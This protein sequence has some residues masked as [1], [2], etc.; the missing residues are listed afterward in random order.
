MVNRR[1]FLTSATLLPAALG[2][3]QEGP[4]G[5]AVE[6]PVEKITPGEKP[7]VAVCHVGFRPRVG[8]KTLVVRAAAG[9]PAKEL[10][11]GVGAR[12][13]M[14]FLPGGASML[15]HGIVIACLLACATLLQGQTSTGTIQGQVRDASGAVVPDARV[16]ITNLRTGVLNELRTN[17]EGRYVMPF[18]L[19]G[20]YAIAVEK[21]GFQRFSRSGI[22]LDVGQNE[23]VD[24]TLAV[25]DVATTVQVEG[26]PPPLA[27][28]SST[29]ATVIEN[30]RIADL[31]L[32]GRNPFDLAALSPGVIPMA[33]GGLGA[34]MS[35]TP[36]ISGGRDANSEISIDGTSIVL[37]ENNVS[38]TTMAFTPS[39]DAIQEFSVMTNTL[40]A[41][42][43]RSGGGVINVAT[44]QGANQLHGSAFEFFRNSEL[45]AN[46]F[47]SN[48]AGIPRHAFQR[49][50]FGGTIGGPVEVPGV[51]RGRN[52]TFFFFD[53]QSTRQ[54]SFSQ[55]TNTMPLDAWRNGDFS[56]LRNSAGAPLLIYDPLTTRPD[57]QG[58]YTR[59]PF[60]GNQIPSARIDPVVRKTE[61]YFPEPNT[62]PI[63]P[64]TQVNNYIM[65]G[66][67]PTNDDRFD[68]RLDHNISDRWRIFGRFSHQFNKVTPVNFFNNVAT[69]SGNGPES[70]SF[71]SA[72]LDQTYTLN[73]TTILNLRYGFGRFF[74]VRRPFSAGFDMTTLGFPQAVRDQAATELLAFPRFD[75]NGISSIG[76]SG[77]TNVRIVPNSHILHGDLTRVLSRHTLKL[78]VEYRKLLE[79][80]LQDAAPDGTYSFNQQWTQRDPVTPSSTAGFGFASFLL[81]IPSSGSISHEPATAT[82]SSY[83]AAYIQDDFHATSNLTLNLGLRY[84]VDVP[85]TE[86]YN[87]LSYF[88]LNEPSPIAGRVPGFPNLVGAMHFVTPGHRQQ[89]P[90]DW[91]N[92]GP[93]FGFAYKIGSKTVARGGYGIMYAP[94]V[95]QA[96]G[97][98]GTM[99]T[100]GITSST[101]FITSLDGRI[102]IN[103]VSNPFPN[104]FNLP[105]GATPGPTSGPSTDLGLG[106]GSSWFIDY[107]NALIQQWNF[108]VQRDLFSNTVIELGYVASKGNHLVDGE[109]GMAYNQ[110]PSSFFSLGNSLNNLV[111]NPFYGII[112]NPT[113]VLSQPTV[114]LA[115]LLRPYP[116]Y[117]SLSP[118]RKPQAN[119]LYH[120]FTLRAEKRYSQ[121]LGFLLS[122]TFGKLI[123]DASSTVTFLGP[124][125]NKQ[126]FYN[127]KAERAVSTQDVSSRL[128][129]STVY[130]LP[131]GRGRKF[132]NN[133]G[134]PWQFIF[135][136]WQ[137]NGILTFQTGTPVILT[138]T[139]NNTALGSP[140]QRPNNNGQSAHVS[141]GSKDSRLKQ[142][143]NTSVFSF[144]PPFTFGNVGRT[145]PDVRN[146]GQR[147]ADL[148]LFKNFRFREDRFTLQFRA[149]AFNAINTAQFG[150]PGAQ[151]G[152]SNLGVIS[153]S[154]V[155]AR[156]MQLALKLLF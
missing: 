89:T 14:P 81:G 56:G 121:G 12:N 39:V 88:N 82:A 101:N 20:D 43:G 110:L 76:A 9:A 94:S 44:K 4:P 98:T 133:A 152:S 68:V 132:M 32:N 31:P 107:R 73:P 52:R 36:S 93:R 6:D 33:P 119:S 24:V 61:A 48:R 102:P 129:I 127:R 151:V 105:L 117:T 104:G 92:F 10:M 54:R 27:T 120:S 103:F 134:E 42:Y 70:F 19:P 13:P 113:S 77:F 95:M 58:G 34:G 99:G 111:P 118:S 91:N 11:T 84:E 23:S 25:G 136:G 26:T 53:E 18:L 59:D 86:R 109:G 17:G 2:A 8:R 135:G 154:G 114:T 87:R 138:Q 115:Q 150:P 156:Q 15:R 124:S 122:Y 145:L 47:F 67:S 106:A 78:G 63:N 147:N 79:N 35:P 75:I 21:P 153:S 49:N 128:V 97:Y 50:Q 7:T 29:L 69:P 80:F 146:P 51:Y 85:R 65:V 141:G 116:Q 5:P 112:V 123:D 57:G 38:I 90:T 140:G 66:K 126:D 71:Y 130:D 72:S 137:T 40:S 41:E 46:D 155:S 62:T 55:F 64:F 125:G 3:Q 100:E 142:W 22:K 28:N 144:A 30:K 148:S 83:W 149:E 37:P 139:Q 96:A 131:L 108:N 1:Q 60:P 143:F 74:D 45:D 16:T